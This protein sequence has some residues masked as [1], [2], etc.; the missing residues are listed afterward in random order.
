MKKKRS[1]SAS[2]VNEFLFCPIGY[3]YLYVDRLIKREPPNIY[4]HYGSCMHEA[5]AFN[6][7]QK[8]TSKKDE[9]LSKVQKVFETNFWKGMNE[10]VLQ[11]WE[12]ARKDLIAEMGGKVLDAYMKEIAPNYQPILVEKRFELELDN[13]DFMINGF[14][15]L[16]LNNG[17]IRDHKTVGKTFK[18]DWNQKTVDESMQLTWYSLAY[19][20]Q[21]KKK[22]KG[23]RL[24]LLPRDNKPEFVSLTSV[25]TDKE[26][27]HILELANKIQKVKE[28]GVYL[29]NVSNCS[30]YCP[31]VGK[32]PKLPIGV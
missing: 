17:D 13:F 32:C 18:R 22:E 4:M 10:V 1:I 25:R 15:D 12:H 11:P 20:K 2:Q 28:I 29:P 24:D 26:I 21:F 14:I 9:E 23:V 7:E 19:R 5:L 16:V 6:F 3:K 31:Y 27:L 30:K 8:I